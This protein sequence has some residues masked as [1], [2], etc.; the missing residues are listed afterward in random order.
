[1]NAKSALCWPGLVV[2]Q[3]ALF[4]EPTPYL[5]VLEGFDVKPWK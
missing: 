3:K 5:I 1:M 2:T 4:G